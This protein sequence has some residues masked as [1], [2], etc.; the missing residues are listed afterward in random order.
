MVHP[1]LPLRTIRV[2]FA[3]VSE[4]PVPSILSS[5]ESKLFDPEPV[6]TVPTAQ[7]PL[8]FRRVKRYSDVNNTAP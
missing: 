6:R 4:A 8:A 1:A 3:V 2:G 7:N 5:L